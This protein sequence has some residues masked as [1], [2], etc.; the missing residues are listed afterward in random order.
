MIFSSASTSF[1][2]A[3]LMFV[4]SRSVANAADLPSST[5]KFEAREGGLEQ[6]NNN[7]LSAM[8]GRVHAASRNLF[9]SSSA[10][11]ALEDDG[12]FCDWVETAFG[13]DFVEGTGQ[14]SCA[15]SGS[16]N[17]T[18]QLGCT[19]EDICDGSVCGTMSFK[20]TLS[21]F[22]MDDEGVGESPTLVIDACSNITT[23]ELEEMC[24]SLD[25]AGPDFDVPKSCDFTYDGIACV[26]KIEEDEPC[27]DWDCSG[28]VPES[29]AEHMYSHECK[30]VTFSDGGAGTATVSSFLPAVQEAPEGTSEADAPSGAISA[31]ETA[32]GT[33]AASYGLVCLG[34]ASLLF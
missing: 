30:N 7:F 15:C 34:V 17:G 10:R 8:H 18:I 33:I 9:D 19:F 22:W 2:G 16:L 5:S 24:I 20:A 26:C 21:G 23:S 3:L 31:K 12:T 11:R 4:A 25:Y 27:I 29:V 13:S 32:V 28:V 14:G 1:F 6:K